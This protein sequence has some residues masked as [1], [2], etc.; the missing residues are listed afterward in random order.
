[1]KYVSIFSVTLKSAMTPSF[2][3]LM[4]T[5]LPG[6]RPSISFASRPT[7]TTSPLDLFIATIEGSLTTMPLPCANT[8]VFAVPRSMARSEEKRLNT[9][10]ML[11]PFL[12]IP[13]SPYREKVSAAGPAI[14]LTTSRPVTTSIVSGHHDQ[15]K[16]A[17]VST[18]ELLLRN[19]DGHLLHRRP[20]SAIRPDNRNGVLSR[21]ERLGEMT[22]CSIRS[23]VRHRLTIH[24]QR[25]TRFC[26][27]HDLR[28]VPVQLGCVNLEQHRLRLALRDEHKLENLTHFTGLFFPIRR[29]DIPEVVAGVEPGD[30]RG[31]SA[32]LGFLHGLREHRRGA[33]PQRIGYGILNG[34]PFEANRR[35]LRIFR[36]DR[37]EVQRLDELGRRQH[38]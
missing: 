23:D 15:R 32:D 31:R 10:L 3:G 9:D 29:R 5:T 2:I 26:P 6:V 11:K 14:A 24:D 37:C 16:G 17:G 13:T 28:H 18:S 38:V 22:E 12:F 30:F 20:T 25:R 21:I 19:H 35:D 8:S 1:M 27:A 36:Y 4:A 33:D 7:A 34:L